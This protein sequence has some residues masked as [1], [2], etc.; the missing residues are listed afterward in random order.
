MAITAS[1][2]AAAGRS[3]AR[4]SA[5][6]SFTISNVALVGQKVAPPVVR[7][8]WRNTQMA[9]NARRADVAM[10]EVGRCWSVCRPDVGPPDHRRTA[11]PSAQVKT[12]M[13]RRRA[14]QGGPNVGRTDVPYGR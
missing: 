14:G 8:S 5:G 9:A 13:T 6:A 3:Q 12:V 4:L 2:G 7:G 11:G 10:A 1:V